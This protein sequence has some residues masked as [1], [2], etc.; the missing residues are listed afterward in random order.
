V[1]LSTFPGLAITITILAA[2]FVGDYLMTALDPRDGIHITHSLATMFA[3]RRA[4]AGR[5]RAGAA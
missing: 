5:A 3:G 2:N 1:W 4:A